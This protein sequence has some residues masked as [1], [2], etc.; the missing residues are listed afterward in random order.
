MLFYTRYPMFHMGD[1]PH[2]SPR[3]RVRLLSYDGNKYVTVMLDNGDKVKIKSGYLDGQPN[4]PRAFRKLLE[5]H[6]VRP[7]CDCN[8]VRDY[9]WDGEHIVRDCP[10]C[11]GNGHLLRPN[12]NGGWSVYRCNACVQPAVWGGVWSS[13]CATGSM[14]DTFTRDADGTILTR[15]EINR[16]SARPNGFVSLGSTFQSHHETVLEVMKRSRKS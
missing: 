12:P 10:N 3:R 9:W 13:G 8:H 2:G 7:E 1:A 16:E 11:M 14:D 5:R 4:L 6:S 15:A